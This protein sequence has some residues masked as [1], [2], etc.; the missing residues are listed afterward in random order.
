MQFSSYELGVSGTFLL[1]LSNL[2]PDEYGR[3]QIFETFDSVLW[4]FDK[5]KEIDLKVPS[6]TL[7]DTSDQR[8]FVRPDGSIMS[9][10]P[11]LSPEFY[12]SLPIYA[13]RAILEIR[14]EINTGS[15]PI[16][17]AQL[18]FMA[19]NASEEV[20]RSLTCS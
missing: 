20:R 15:D 16:A 7:S 14:N 11:G 1:E 9:R 6:Y 3:Q 19:V 17:Q 12:R 5:K 4:A 8:V 13:L 18:C 2:F 10:C